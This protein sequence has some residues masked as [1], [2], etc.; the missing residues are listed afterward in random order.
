M[1]LVD[2][3]SAIDL[4]EVQKEAT[5]LIAIY[6]AM[7]MEVNIKDQ[8]EAQKKNATLVAANKATDL[9]AI[10]NAKDQKEAQKKATNRVDIV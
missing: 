6:N 9:D 8:G 4:G 2:I 1:N 10:I 3:I 7:D 5:N